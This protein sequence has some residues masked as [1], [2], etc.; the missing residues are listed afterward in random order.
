MRR[1]AMSTVPNEAGSAQVSWRDFA[2]TNRL[3]IFGVQG[4][5]CVAMPEGCEGFPAVASAGGV[6]GPGF[7]IAHGPRI[8]QPA[9]T[10]KRPIYF[11]FRTPPVKNI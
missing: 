7:F 4:L 8:D 2:R 1:V 6:K 11:R 9:P 10:T 3:C 5:A